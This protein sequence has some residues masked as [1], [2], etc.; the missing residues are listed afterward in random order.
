MSDGKSE[1]TATAMLTSAEQAMIKL[2]P[3][4]RDIVRSIDTGIS[5]AN[6]SGKEMFVYDLPTTFDC[7]RV[8]RADAQILVY[9]ELIR[10]YTS[11]HR[12]FTVK[13]VPGTR[14]KLGVSWKHGIP[15]SEKETR[16]NLIKS[17]TVQ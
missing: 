9:S 3:F 1:I 16:V 2:K 10:I 11:P 13:F 17:Y 14:P 15:D 12:G 4:I 7:I 8:P 5:V 6:A